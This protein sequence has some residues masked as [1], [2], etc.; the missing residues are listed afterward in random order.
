MKKPWIR[1]VLTLGILSAL[2][3][4]LLLS[5]AG[6]AAPLTKAKVKK[7]ATKVFNNNIGPATAPFMRDDVTRH[8]ASS[9]INSDAFK[10]LSVDCPPGKIALS[11]GGWVAAIF[12]SAE[13]ALTASFP[14]GQNP[15]TTTPA[16]AWT[17]WGQNYGPSG[18]WSL[19]VV[20]VCVTP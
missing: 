8:Q 14:T 16:T 15:Q 10:S 13:P 1:G 18:S 9:A 19:Q 11:G 4:G 12:S 2:A 3:A 17:V 20:V 7:I 5:P 6:A